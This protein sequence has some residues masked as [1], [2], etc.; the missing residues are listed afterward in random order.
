MAPLG[1]LKGW[2]W[3]FVGV[4]G[5]TSESSL[6]PRVSRFG[7]NALVKT[8]GRSAV[9]TSKVQHMCYKPPKFRNWSAALTPAWGQP[10]IA[11]EPQSA[12]S[13]PRLSICVVFHTSILLDPYNAKPP[14][15][16]KIRPPRAEKG[17]VCKYNL[18]TP[19][20]SAL[21]LSSSNNLAPS[22]PFLYC[23][24]THNPTTSTVWHVPIV[25]TGKAMVIRHETNRGD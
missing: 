4:C 14:S 2:V 3:A 20:S 7:S 17:C 13:P 6:P 12:L 23:G 19:C 9:F 1:G 10:R 8:G 11:L 15:S 24:K 5:M 22:P 25:K 16:P 21:A 18:R